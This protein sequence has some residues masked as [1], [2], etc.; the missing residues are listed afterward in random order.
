MESGSRMEQ[1]NQNMPWAAETTKHDGAYLT[2]ATIT[3][4]ATRI[5]NGIFALCFGSTGATAFL[6]R[7]RST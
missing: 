3:Y 4:D 6:P 2:R 7:A 1:P 5:E